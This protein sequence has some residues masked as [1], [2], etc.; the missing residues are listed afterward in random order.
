MAIQPFSYSRKKK[1]LVLVSRGGGGH[2]SA[3]DALLQILGGSYDVEINYVFEKI[4]RPIDFLNILTKGHYTGEDLY[5]SLLKNHQKK[6]LQLLVNPV[7]YLSH[8]HIG[9]FIY[10]ENYLL[11]RNF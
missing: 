7:L 4:L 10:L 8:S 5:N 9:F 1:I 3:G 11:V 2:K 6:L